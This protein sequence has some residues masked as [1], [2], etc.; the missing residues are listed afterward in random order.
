M[1][2]PGNPCPDCARMPLYGKCPWHSARLVEFVAK[3][4]KRRERKEGKR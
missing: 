2:R 1:T 4:R 3:E